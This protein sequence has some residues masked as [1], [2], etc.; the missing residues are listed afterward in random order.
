[1]SQV[2]PASEFSWLFSVFDARSLSLQGRPVLIALNIPYFLLEQLTYEDSSSSHIR[3][4]LSWLR[5]IAFSSYFSFARNFTVLDPKISRFIAKYRVLDRT[6]PNF[7]NGN[8]MRER[9]TQMSPYHFDSF[10]RIVKSVG[11]LV[12]SCRR[13]SKSDCTWVVG[14]RSLRALFPVGT[15]RFGC[16]RQDCV[17][18]AGIISVIAIIIIRSPYQLW[19]LCD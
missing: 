17:P 14:F 16:T 19:I 10:C 9:K 6:S 15:N 3:A 8:S 7:Q 2:L 1:M 13:G 11:R 4:N 18:A 12:V 5:S